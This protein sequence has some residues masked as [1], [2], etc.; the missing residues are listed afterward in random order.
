MGLFVFRNG[1]DIDARVHDCL[2]E[3]G[4][5]SNWI[6]VILCSQWIIYLYVIFY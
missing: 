4:E 1:L 2:A 3:V 5:G 6:S